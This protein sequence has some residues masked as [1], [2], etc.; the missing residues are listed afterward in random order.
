MA[1]L[2]TNVRRWTFHETNLGPRRKV[3]K[4]H[5][6]KADLLHAKM[7]SE[8]LHRAELIAKKVGCICIVFCCG[9]FFCH[10]ILSDKPSVCIEK[11]RIFIRKHPLFFV[12]S[13]PPHPLHPTQHLFSSILKDS[14]SPLTENFIFKNSGFL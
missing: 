1:Q 8:L 6:S 13:H 10:R 2:N 7:T 14:P 11:M 4:R 12:R 3:Q 9:E 5:G